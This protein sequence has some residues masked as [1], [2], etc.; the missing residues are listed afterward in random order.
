MP[1][2]IFYIDELSRPI[3]DELMET[4]QRTVL[5]LALTCRSLEE[6][7]LSSLWKEQPSLNALVKVLPSHN[8]AQ[9]EDDRGFVMVVSGCNLLVDHT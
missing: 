7:A 6:P 1:H 9:F 8:L 5:S 3:I 2:P 4:S